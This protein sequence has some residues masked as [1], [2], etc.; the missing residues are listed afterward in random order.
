MK[1][2]KVINELYAEFIGNKAR[3]YKVDGTSQQEVNLNQVPPELQQVIKKIAT[4]LIKKGEYKDF[5]AKNFKNFDVVPKADGTFE[6]TNDAGE[7]YIYK[8]E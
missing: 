6:I 4:K 1:F 8:V 3:F 2:N 7:K 5:E